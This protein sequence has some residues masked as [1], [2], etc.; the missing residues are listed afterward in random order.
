MQRRYEKD[1][2][3]VIWEPGRCLHSQVCFRGLPAVFDPRKRPWIRMEGATAEAIVEQVR[4]C[5]SGALSL[6]E[7]APGLPKE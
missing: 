5:P 1:G 3:T 7:P 4:K 2:I 6:G